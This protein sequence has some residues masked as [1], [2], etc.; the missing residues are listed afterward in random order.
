MKHRV[1][2]VAV[3]H[4]NASGY[5]YKPP[6]AAPTN[7]M[8]G[9]TAP[10]RKSG[11]GAR[12]SAA[13]QA[14]AA[15]GSMGQ[16]SF[17]SLPPQHQKLIQALATNNQQQLCQLMKTLNPQTASALTELLKQYVHSQ[18]Q[19]STTAVPQQQ[20][21][22][23]GVPS[24]TPAQ[25]A[26]EAKA[27]EAVVQAATESAIKTAR[28]LT[29][30]KISTARQQMRRDLEQQMAKLP[31]PKPAVPDMYFVPNGNQ[32]DFCYLLGLDLT[33][34]RVLKDKNVFK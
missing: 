3:G 33:V 23:V 12:A 24:I 15:S 26:K 14:N 29:Q 30:Q 4:Q 18:Q 31:P 27:R 10:D 5:A 17:A 11:K 21:P 19:Q 13:A 1:N 28:E 8:N 20:A 25:L 9:T 16:I 32:P 7:K 2:N 22:A 6:V 34:Q